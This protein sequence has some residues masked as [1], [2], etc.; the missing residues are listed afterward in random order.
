MK[1]KKMIA[2]MSLM[3]VLG[4]GTMLAGNKSNKYN[5]THNDKGYNI[6]V[7]AGRGHQ[8]NDKMGQPGKTYQMNPTTPDKHQKALPNIC[9]HC[10]KQDK[11]EKKC[12]YYDKHGDNTTGKVATT[13][14]VTA[15]VTT[16]LAAL[17]N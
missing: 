2:T 1:T 13:V 15:A 7:Q 12:K 11:H 9:Q 10:K 17:M 5:N 3:M 6:E 14:A 16:L 8:N 4:T